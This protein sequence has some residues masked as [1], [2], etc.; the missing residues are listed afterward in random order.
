MKRM[1]TNGP[2][3]LIH[4]IMN[5]ELLI[6]LRDH[7]AKPDCRFVYRYWVASI[8][9]NLFNKDGLLKYENHQDIEYTD[10]VSEIDNDEYKCDTCACVAGWAVLLNKDN[11]EEYITHDEFDYSDSIPNIA[12]ELLDL[13]TEQRSF[14]FYCENEFGWPKVMTH[15]ATKEEAIKRINYLLEN[16][17]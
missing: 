12:T 11:L 2:P 8:A 9:D 17:E 7:I 10:H 3:T 15:R 5:K 4:Q 16:F 1:V 13:T 14:L 6:K